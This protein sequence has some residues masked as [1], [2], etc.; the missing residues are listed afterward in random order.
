MRLTDP[1]TQGIINHRGIRLTSKLTDFSGYLIFFGSIALAV[2][3]LFNAQHLDF[4]RLWTFTNFSG[5]AGGGIW[6]ETHNILYLFLLGL[7][8]P[9]Y[10]ITGFDASAH[11]AEETI[12]AARTGPRAD[13]SVLWSCVFGWAICAVVLAAPDIKEAAARPQPV[14]LDHGPCAERS[15]QLLMYV[16]IGAAQYLC[17][18]PP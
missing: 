9:A 1:L 13:L 7:L 11:T 14:L 16:V 5:D 4:S 3:L 10:T 15:A 18:S 12:A 8:L 2:V 17:V 6:P